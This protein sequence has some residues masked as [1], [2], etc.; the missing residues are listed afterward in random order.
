MLGEHDAAPSASD[1][2][3]HALHCE[4]YIAMTMPA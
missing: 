1:I 2:V 3:G 4:Y